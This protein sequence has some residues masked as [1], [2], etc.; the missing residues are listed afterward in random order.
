ME[1]WVIENDG[2][3]KYILGVADTVEAA[4][5]IVKTPYAAPYIVRWE[6]PK[7]DGDRWQLTGH[8]TGVKGYCGDGPISWSFTPYEVQTKPLLNT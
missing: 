6:E 7:Q 3:D 5:K 1:V 8:F 2:Y 4:A